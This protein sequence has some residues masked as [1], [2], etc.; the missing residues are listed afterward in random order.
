MG[1]ERAIRQIIGGAIEHKD[2]AS[3]LT[4]LLGRSA[5]NFIVQ[6]IMQIWAKQ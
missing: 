4:N 2:A 3:L 1:D 5:P 6:S